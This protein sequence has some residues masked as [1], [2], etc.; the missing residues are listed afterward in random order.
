MPSML[1]KDVGSF[2]VAVHYTL[3]VQVCETICG[4][5]QP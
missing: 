4:I 2:Q 3:L 5:Q 1:Q